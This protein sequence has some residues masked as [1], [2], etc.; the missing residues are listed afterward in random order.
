MPEETKEPLGVSE[1]V[2]QLQSEEGLQH[3]DL[4]VLLG[5]RRLPNLVQ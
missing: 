1:R 2:G 3:T 4:G 5:R